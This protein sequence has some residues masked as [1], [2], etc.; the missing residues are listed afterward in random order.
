MII[1]NN[2]KL[3]TLLNFL[4]IIGIFFCVYA[5]KWCVLVNIEDRL[6]WAGLVRVYEEYKNGDS[7]VY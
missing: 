5:N 2:F 1:K 4:P 7:D 6:I 3:I